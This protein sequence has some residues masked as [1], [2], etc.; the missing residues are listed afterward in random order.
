MTKKTIGVLAAA[1]A[2]VSAC[3]V[4][5]ER[6]LPQPGEVGLYRG[7]PCSELATDAQQTH[8]HLSTLE[9]EQRRTHTI[10][11]VGVA[12]LL[13]PIGSLMGGNHADEIGDLKW[14]DHVLERRLADGH[15]DAG[16][17]TQNGQSGGGA[18]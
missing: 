17:L 6:I 13:M 4:S 1:A 15:C 8:A 18:N 7:L 10:D 14:R 11:T 16:P 3:A 12:L 9:A 5:P 2:C